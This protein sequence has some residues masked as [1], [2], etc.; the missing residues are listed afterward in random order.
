MEKT[1]SLRKR[2]WEGLAKFL[3]ALS[4]LVFLPAWSLRYWQAWVF[5]L[6]FGVSVTLITAHFLRTDPAL[7]ERRLNVGATAEKEPTQKRIQAVASVLFIALVAFPGFDHHFGWSQLSAYTS[8]GGDALVALGLLVVFLVFR[9]N[10]FTS[11]IVEVHQQQRVISS[12]PYRFVRHPMYAGSLIFMMGIPLALG[13][14][15]GLLLSIP[16]AA[17]LVWRLV[18]EEKYLSIN[19]PGYAEYRVNTPY[20]LLPGIY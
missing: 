2:A 1:A 8:L 19:L 6:V 10:S 3:I 5:L 20:R 16:M 4:V 9:E 14:A 11:A 7:V 17:T 12:G 13:S 15:W 18:D